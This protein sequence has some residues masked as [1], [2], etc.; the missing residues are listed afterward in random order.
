MKALTAHAAIA[1]VHRGT[2]DERKIDVKMLSSMVVKKADNVQRNIVCWNV[3]V[4]VGYNSKGK[5]LVVS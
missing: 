5:L 4:F 2:A 3:P 1:R